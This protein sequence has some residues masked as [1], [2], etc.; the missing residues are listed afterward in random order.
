MGSLST[1]KPC[2]TDAAQDAAHLLRQ[3]IEEDILFVS[4]VFDLILV[5]QQ[6]DWYDVYLFTNVLRLTMRT[7]S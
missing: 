2:V 1:V 6:V 3:Q 5:L 4:T 7:S